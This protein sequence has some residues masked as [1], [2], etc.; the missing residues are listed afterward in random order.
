[1]IVI[2]PAVQMIGKV[3]QDLFV[4]LVQKSSWSSKKQQSITLSSIEVVYTAA[5]TTTFQTIW[6]RRILEEQK[7]KQEQ[8][9]RIVTL[10]DNKSAISMSKNSMQQERTNHIKTCYHFI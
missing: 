6:L 4:A 3:Q 8:D 10:C 5:T 7:Q 9:E 2:R 1:M